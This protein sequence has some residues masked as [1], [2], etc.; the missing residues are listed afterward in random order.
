MSLF[1]PETRIKSLEIWKKAQNIN[2]ILVS[3]PFI[4]IQGNRN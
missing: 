2:Y 3:R 1:L 4:A